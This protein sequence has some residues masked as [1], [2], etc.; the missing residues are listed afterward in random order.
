MGCR[1]LLVMEAGPDRIA[2]ERDLAEA[3]HE[4]VSVDAA[5]SA[6]EILYAGN[7]QCIVIDESISGRY[8]LQ[9]ART[10]K[11][12]NPDVGLILVG[13]DHKRLSDQ[14][15]G[16]AIWDTLPKTCS[17]SIKESVGEVCEFVN[18]PAEQA[19]ALCAEFD[20]EATTMRKLGHDALNDTGFYKPLK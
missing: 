13:D 2:I 10:I 7:L 18:M 17:M 6:L 8:G 20:R 14:V 5:A 9:L 15:D 12:Y 11:I 1:V 4:C 3:G 16:M 19:R